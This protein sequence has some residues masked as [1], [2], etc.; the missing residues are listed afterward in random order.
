MLLPF[1]EDLIVLNE[2][3]FLKTPEAA[4]IDFPKPE[5]QLLVFRDQ[6]TL[7]NQETKAAF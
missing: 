4:F 3:C 7:F 6:N 5:K 2:E 1:Q